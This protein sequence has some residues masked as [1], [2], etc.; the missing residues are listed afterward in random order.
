MEIKPEIQLRQTQKLVMTPQLQ[1]AIKM[2]QLSNIELAERIDQELEENPALEIDEADFE[3]DTVSV[4]QSQETENERAETLEEEFY[5]ASAVSET[6]EG[7]YKYE[8]KEYSHLEQPS[9]ADKKRE[10]IEGTVFRE[11]TLKEH[12]LSQISLLTISERQAEACELITGY[13][14]TMGYITI[15]LEE[16]HKGHVSGGTKAPSPDDA[17]HAAFSLEELEGALAIIQSLDPPGVGARDITECLLL[18]LRMKGSYPLAERIIEDFLNEIKLRKLDEISKKLKVPV[19]KVNDA[20]NIISGLEPYPGRQF[21]S[22]EIKYII[23][24]VIIEEN[25][26]GFEVIANNSFIPKLR[27]NGYFENLMRRKKSDKRIKGFVSE[28]VQSA[29]NFIHWIEQRESTLVRVTRAILEEQLDFFKHGPKYLKPLVLKDIA[30]KLDLHESTISR[31]TSSKY[32]QTQYGVFQLKYFFSNTI[33]AYGSREYS[34]TSIKEMI[35]DII[36]DE[37][38]KRQLSDQKIAEFLSQRGIKIARRTIAKYRKELNILPSNL[39][40]K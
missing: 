33:P 11:E 22:G 9:V 10:F 34:S 25:E 27:V 4:E 28:K 7:E 32:V 20:F 3:R 29:K 17:D 8:N 2:L 24:D 21:Y 40:R 14:D 13:M 12:L 16:I 30:A 19:S 15:P 18:Q 26:D 38:S 36:Q 1:Q 5:D 39:R 31:I 35:K 23:P 6:Y 37:K